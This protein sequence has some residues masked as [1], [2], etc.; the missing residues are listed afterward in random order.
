M[1][2]SCATHASQHAVGRCPI[3]AR[4]FCAACAFEDVPAEL[5]FC[6]EACRQSGARP[7]VST[8]RSPDLLIADLARPIRAGWGL[9]F[10]QAGALSLEIGLPLGVA[11]GVL[12]AMLG[13]GGDV[14]KPDS[15]IVSAGVGSVALALL[16]MSAV[17]LRLSRA[18]AGL[19]ARSPWPEAAARFVPWLVTW[20]L[21]IACVLVGTLLLFVPGMIANVRLFWADEFALVHGHGPLAAL[22]KSADLTRGLG[23]RVFAFQLLLGFAEYVVLIPIL[24]GFVAVGMVEQALPAN[25]VST[26]ATSVLTAVLLV[27]AYASLHAPEVV[28]FYGLRALRAS[29]PAEALEGDWVASGLRAR[30]R[31]ATT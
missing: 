10:R 15:T 5:S 26:V 18:H 1:P 14:E 6:S 25:L 13:S 22:R 31:E 27:N 11:Y 21:F 28:Y 9:W 20:V 2:E 29:L 12:A 23:W 4:P 7:V 19:P 8:G 24:L 30:A 3:C 16:G 17:A